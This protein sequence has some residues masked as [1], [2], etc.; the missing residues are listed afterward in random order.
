MKRL[1]VALVALVAMFTIS[2]AFAGEVY[3]RKIMTITA[4][5]TNVTWTVGKYDRPTVI[6]IESIGIIPAVCT[7]AVTVAYNDDGGSSNTVVTFTN[8]AGVYVHDFAFPRYLQYGDVVH[9]HGQGTNGSYRLH[10]IQRDTRTI[11]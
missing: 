8:S 7:S 11:N 6:R 9:V 4:N 3:A 5:S 1:I 10:Y 2:S